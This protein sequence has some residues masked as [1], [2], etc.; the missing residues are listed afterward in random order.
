MFCKT[1]R[2]YFWTN[3]HVTLNNN[4]KKTNKTKH[5]FQ[6]DRKS[7]TPVP[8][9][10]FKCVPLLIKCVATVCC[11]TWRLLRGSI[12]ITGPMVL[13][14]KEISILWLGIS[15]VW[16]GRGLVGIT[17]KLQK[18]ILILKLVLKRFWKSAISNDT[19]FLL[20]QITDLFLLNWIA[21]SVMCCRALLVKVMSMYMWP[22]RRENV[23]EISSPLAFTAGSHTW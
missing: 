4:L 11:F 9:Q 18:H 7:K 16:T 19:T 13:R 5:T 22:W 3:G 8:G 21:K 20:S 6:K 2:N 12:F 1:L 15:G 23:P 14:G 10:V 17:P